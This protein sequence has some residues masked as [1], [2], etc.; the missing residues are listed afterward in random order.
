M[1]FGSWEGLRWD[2]IPAK[3]LDAW[4]DDLWEYKPGGA[5]SAAMVAR[6]FGSW[7][8]EL[9]NSPLESALA[10]THAGVIRVALARN[11][12]LDLTR[13]ASA[14]IDFGGVY[15]IEIAA[16]GARSRAGLEA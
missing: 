5:E 13:W 16:G 12:L 11:G 8:T 15:R 10:V 6:R 4:A 3:E 14:P 2:R 9:Q 1:S 7:L